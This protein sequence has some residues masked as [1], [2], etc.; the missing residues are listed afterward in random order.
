MK[1]DDLKPAAS[2]VSPEDLE[3]SATPSLASFDAM[4]KTLE[5]VEPRPDFLRTLRQI[6]LEHPRKSG[7]SFEFFGFRLALGLAASLGLGIL[8]G[9]LPTSNADSN[10]ELTAFLDLDAQEQPLDLGYFE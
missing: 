2:R 10:S 7:S 8:V 3:S 6:P 5:S 1:T 9:H 4:F